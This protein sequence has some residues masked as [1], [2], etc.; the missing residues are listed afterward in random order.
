MLRAD[1]GLTYTVSTS[2]ANILNRQFESV[3][4]KKTSQTS[5][6]YIGV[7][8]T[9]SLSSIAVSN[10]G[11]LKQLNNLDISKASGPD[12]IP[13]RLLKQY[14]PLIAST[15]K[16]IYQNSIDQGAIPKDWK[17]ANVTPLIKKGDRSNAS[18]YRP[19]S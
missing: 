14:A 19:M 10:D 7:N 16:K 2:K 15:L 6:A 11:V 17:K 3:F 9:Q 13:A 5:F 1:N 8:V 18:N 4:N 12:E